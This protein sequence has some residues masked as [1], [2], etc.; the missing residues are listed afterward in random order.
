MCMETGEGVWR[1]VGGSGGEEE[2]KE[3][4]QDRMSDMVCDTMKEGR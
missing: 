2:R 1:C 4:E 3:A